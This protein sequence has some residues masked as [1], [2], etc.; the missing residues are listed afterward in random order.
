MV[1]LDTLLPCGAF[2]YFSGVMFSKHEIHKNINK[3][4]PFVNSYNLPENDIYY[5]LNNIDFK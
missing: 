3:I 5:S 1:V 2:P 4:R